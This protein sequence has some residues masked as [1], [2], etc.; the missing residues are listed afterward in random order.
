MCLACAGCNALL[1]QETGRGD[2]L[3]ASVIHKFQRDSEMSYEAVF[4]FAFQ[5]TAQILKSLEERFGSRTFHEALREVS[6]RKAAN[7]VAKYSQT[8]PRNDL[9]AFAEI[10]RSPRPMW[11]SSLT[12]EIVEDSKDVFELRVSECLWAKTMLDI[13]AGEIGFSYFCFA[14]YASAQAFNPELRMTRTKTLM[15][16]DSHC[17]HR[18]AMETASPVPVDSKE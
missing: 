3:D 8:L 4:R 15:Q 1:A 2:S 18:Y 16:G 12:Y 17:N 5:G 6:S 13:D 7:T 10:F 14:D 11:Q 9:N